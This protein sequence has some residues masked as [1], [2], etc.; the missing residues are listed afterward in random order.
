MA[1]PL[2]DVSKTANPCAEVFVPL[3]RP[4]VPMHLFRNY[5]FVLVT[6]ISAVGGMIYYSMNGTIP[7]DVDP[8]FKPLTSDQ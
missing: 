5:N 1:F 4:I 7:L 2:E 8:H 6:I 3:R